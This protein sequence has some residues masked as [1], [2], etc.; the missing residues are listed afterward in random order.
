MRR[1]LSFAKWALTAAAAVW[2]ICL[3]VEPEFEVD[4]SSHYSIRMQ[5]GNLTIRMW[6]APRVEQEKDPFHNTG[7]DT[8]NIPLWFMAGL[9][10]LAAGVCW[11]LGRA[12]V[13]PPHPVN[14]SH[15]SSQEPP[16]PR[17]GSAE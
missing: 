9:S 3:V 7:P 16:R 10:A 4:L 15:S 11:W 13:W 14:V 1:I 17:T 6:G 12:A 8:H 5:D 2:L